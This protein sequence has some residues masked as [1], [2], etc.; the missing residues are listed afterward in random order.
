MEKY[1]LVQARYPDGSTGSMLKPA[2]QIVRDLGF[3]D[4]SD[5]DYEVFDVSE[6]G[7]VVK[8]QDA[9]TFNAA[10]N[11]HCLINPENG[12]IVIAGYSPEH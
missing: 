3:R 11:Y 4:C 2:A 8:L 7:K 5:T 1:Y 12:A 9:T 10:P 6:Y